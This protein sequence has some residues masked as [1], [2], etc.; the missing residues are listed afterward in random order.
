MPNTRGGT[1][2]THMDRTIRAL[3]IVEEAARI[4]S[5]PESWTQG[6]VVRDKHGVAGHGVTA[7]D[8]EA[9]QFSLVGALIR[10]NGQSGF[11]GYHKARTVLMQLAGRSL[12][13]FN[14]NSTHEQV[15]DLLA[16][17]ALSLQDELREA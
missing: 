8:R 13:D 16:D 2:P 10:A 9:V 12:T 14:D 17:G 6:R 15:L 4:L 3:E 11:T 7:H 1:I 5:D